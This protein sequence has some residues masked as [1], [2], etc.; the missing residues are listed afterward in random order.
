VQ[1]FFLARLTKLDESARGGPEFADPSSGTYDVER[2]DLRGDDLAGID[3]RPVE[4]KELILANSA[5]LL[6]EIAS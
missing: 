6:A 4:L 5:A 2:I 1:H 3:L